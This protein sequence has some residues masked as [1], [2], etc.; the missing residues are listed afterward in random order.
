MMKIKEKKEVEIVS[1]ILCDVCLESTR[2]EGYS[3]QYAILQAHW[4][5]GSAHDG[6]RYEI[7]LCEG[8]FFQAVAS[9]KQ[10]RRTQ[11]M[12]SEDD[13]DKLTDNFGMV[14]VDDFFN[15]GGSSTDKP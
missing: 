6:E 7:H 13:K 2:V 5:Y 8:C 1:D 3:L 4:G 10:E 15:D 11:T 12:F 14:A 9:L